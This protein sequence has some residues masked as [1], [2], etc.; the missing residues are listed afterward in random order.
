MFAAG[1]LPALLVFYIRRY[2]EEPAIAVQA[3]QKL[4]SSAQPSALAIFGRGTLRTTI[5]GAILCSGATGGY[6]AV[7]TWLPTYLNTER[8][9]SIVTSAGYLV[10]LIIGAF[11]GYLFGAWY[12]DRFGRRQLFLFFAVAASLVVTAYTQLP[13]SNEMM[14]FLG[15]PLG[16]VS[17]GHFSGMGPI[18]SELYPTALRGSGQGFT[19]NF[20]RGLGAFFP[21]FVGYLSNY[22]S[23]GNAMT[24][25]AVVSYGIML[26]AAL[27]LPE[28]TGRELDAEA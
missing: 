15:L 19:Y 7:N 3:R 12:A 25:F 21:A 24:V 13:I 20:G 14:L 18:L 27:A 6:Y 5:V 1:A 17:T 26:L 23:L 4:A 22:V 28:T 11:A 8:H 9:L 16:F 2:V 10:V